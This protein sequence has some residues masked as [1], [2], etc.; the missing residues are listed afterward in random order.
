MTKD[1]M[2]K[3]TASLPTKSA[4]IRALDK[5]G[6]TRSEIANYLQIRYQHVRNVLVGPAQL[7]PNGG[8]RGNPSV[9]P[10]AGETLPRVLSLSIDEAKRGLA[11]RFGVSPSAI[12][13]TIKA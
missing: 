3:V 10:T 8:D 6:A 12:E 4:K 2:D 13:I 7:S 11:T 5:L 9:P 1:E